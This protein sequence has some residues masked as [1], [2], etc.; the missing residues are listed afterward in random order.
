MIQNNSENIEAV[1]KA[2]KFPSNPIANF[3]HFL[4]RDTIDLDEFPDI[5]N[6]VSSDNVP[7]WKPFTS[8]KLGCIVLKSSS[9]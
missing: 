5:P 2:G 1:Q 8:G 7:N 3:D 6:D 9:K 4:D